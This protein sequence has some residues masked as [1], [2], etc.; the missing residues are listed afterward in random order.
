MQLLPSLSQGERTVRREQAAGGHLPYARH[1]DDHTL[2]T[3]GGLLSQVLRLRGAHSR[4][5][6]LRNP[7]K[8]SNVAL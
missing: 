6:T 2:E 8:G 5:D 4:L 1:V 3:R 7:P